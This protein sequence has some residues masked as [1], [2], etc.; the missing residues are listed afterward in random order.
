MKK[1]PRTSIVRGVSV[2]MPMDAETFRSLFNRMPSVPNLMQVTGNVKFSVPFAEFDNIM[3]AGWS[4]NTFK[5]STT[6]RVQR[7]KP[8]EIALLE[9]RK[10]FYDHSE[11]LRCQ[12]GE[13]A[14]MACSGVVKSVVYGSYL[15]TISFYRE[16]SKPVPKN[17]VEWTR[18]TW[19]N[20]E[21][22]RNRRPT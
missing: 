21:L 18:L 15:L 4:L 12:G 8:I 16:R 3:P 13:R 22:A 2:T 17:P 19:A 10:V 20:P 6:C 7:G 9:S 1:P 11:C 14:P 5:T